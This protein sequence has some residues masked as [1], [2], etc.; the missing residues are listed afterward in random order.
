VCGF[1]KVSLQ[2]SF[3]WCSLEFCWGVNVKKFVVC[4]CVFVVVLGLF[5][6]LFYQIGDLESRN[7]ELQGQIVDLQNELE[8]VESLELSNWDNW[9]TTSLGVKDINS[10]P[11][12]FPEL[13]KRLFVQGDVWNNGTGTAYDCKLNVRLYQNGILTYDV[14]LELGDIASGSNV[15][16]EQDIVYTGDALSG[17]DILPVFKKW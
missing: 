9:L 4:F 14:Y 5:G 1:V 10:S 12:P 7:A 6:F 16:V 11:Y 8:S 15:F 17:W 2:K 3:F 13:I